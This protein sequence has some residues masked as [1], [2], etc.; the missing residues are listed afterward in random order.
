ME[1]EPKQL[2]PRNENHE[3]LDDMVNLQCLNEAEL[4]WNLKKRYLTNDTIFTY[5]GPTLLIINPYKPIPDLFSIHN[6]ALYQK[7]IN[8][9]SFSLKDFKPHIYAISADVFR[10]LFENG[11]NQAMIIS[12][13]SGVK[14]QKIN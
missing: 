14:K 8:N 13:E 4:L 10:R 9:P 3:E 7:E 5:V 1:C 12:G 2:L 11:G 6:L